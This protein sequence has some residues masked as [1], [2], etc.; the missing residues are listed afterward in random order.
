MDPYDYAASLVG[1]D[2]RAKIAAFWRAFA[3]KADAIEDMF[4]RPGGG[5]QDI[6]EIMQ[7]LN[8]ISSDLMWEF[9]SSDRGSRLCVTAEFRDELRPLAR[10]VR[11]MAPD[12]EQWRFVD[13]RPAE[14]PAMLE[15]IHQNRFGSPIVLEK[16]EA[17][18]GFNGR[19]DQVGEGVGTEDELYLQILNISTLLLGEEVERDWIGQVDATPKNASGL[20]G[21]FGRRGADLFDPIEWQNTIRG[22]VRQTRAEM[23]EVPFAKVNTEAR[24]ILLSTELNMS[25]DHRRNDLM[26]FYATRE[27][28][29]RGVL[30]GARFSSR[31]HSRHGEWFMYLRISRRDEV[32]FDHVDDRSLIED[33]LHDLLS[34]HDLGGVAGA[35]HG[36]ESV[37]IDFAVTDVGKAIALIQSDFR[38]ADFAQG[39]TLH[40][41]DQGLAGIVM[42]AT[43]GKRIH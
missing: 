12:L 27:T 42:P 5:Q 3:S 32:P 21:F 36:R 34:D 16:I 7:K 22:M 40:F 37:Y 9:G 43:I 25:P 1:E 4:S 39:A 30:S 6:V 2:I 38:D 19:I 33:K 17:H 15:Q 29:L 23:P 20:F 11:H 41:L 13:A 24:A 26:T 35:G 28:Y 8:P 14:D 10:L 18:L 31:C